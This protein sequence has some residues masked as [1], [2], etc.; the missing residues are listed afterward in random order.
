MTSLSLF[1][2]AIVASPAITLCYMRYC[3]MI[4]IKKLNEPKSNNLFTMAKQTKRAN[5][6]FSAIVRLPEGK[7]N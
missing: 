6:L 5:N 2:C 7:M 3:N 1:I 4:A